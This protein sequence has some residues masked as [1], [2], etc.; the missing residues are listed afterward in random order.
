MASAEVLGLQQRITALEQALASE[1]A[2]VG[3]IIFFHCGRAL[4]PGQWTELSAS[5]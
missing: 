5:S 1:K 3:K 4:A 2:K